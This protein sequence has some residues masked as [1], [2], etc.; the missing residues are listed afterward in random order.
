MIL[1]EI[2]A[3]KRQELEITKQRL[4]LGEVERLARR[5]PPAKDF[6]TALK[7][8]RIRLIAEV[9]KASPSKGLICADFDPVKTAR[10]YAGNGAAAISI[11]T[12]SRYFQ[13]SLDDLRNVGQALG[14]K[15]PPTL[16]KDFIFD[17]Y[18]VYEARAYGADGLLLIVAILVPEQLHEL[19]V[20]SRSL[21]M[22]PLVE[23][24]S[25]T[26]ALIASGSHAKIIGINNRDLKTFAVDITTTE[27]LRKLVPPNR[28][29]VSESGIK[30]RA[31]MDMVRGWG[32]DAVL[33]GE[34]LMTAPDVA[35]K[36]K[37]LL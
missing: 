12:E 32:V 30:S 26:D 31:D 22:E 13:G 3:N 15:R 23:V 16:R 1:D 34:A 19:I 33:I 6:A 9:K 35:A 4:P 17:P 7:G 8:D 28:I 21:G 11:L 20:L 24:H 10:T 27:R 18:Q 14:D 37:E 29:V 2:V 5:Q 36:M 25:D